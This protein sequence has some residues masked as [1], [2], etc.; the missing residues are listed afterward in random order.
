MFITINCRFVMFRVSGYLK[1]NSLPIIGAVTFVSYL[2][3]HAIKWLIRKCNPIQKIDFTA[4]NCLNQPKPGFFSSLF[5]K[6]V[7]N[8]PQISSDKIT[9]GQGEYIIFHKNPDGTKTPVS[10]EIYTKAYEVLQRY[11]AVALAKDGSETAINECANRDVLIKE[12]LKE[13][14]PTLEAI[15]IPRTLYEL[16]FIRKCINEDKKNGRICHRSDTNYHDQTS[17]SF[18]DQSSYEAYVAKDTKDLK[19]RKCWHLGYFIDEGNN[20]NDK[21]KNV[22]YRLNKTIFKKLNPDSTGLTFQ[23]ILTHAQNEI[24]Y[25][26]KYHENKE[27]QNNEIC[28]VSTLGIS[29]NF[30][31]ETYTPLWYPMG[32]RHD[33]DAQIIKNA[34]ALE[35][36][37]MARHA[38]FLYRGAIFKIDSVLN[39]KNKSGAYSLSYGTS[40]FAGNVYDGGGTAFPYMRNDVLD[41]YAIPVPFNKLK[42]SLFFV[43]SDNT[44]SQLYGGGESFHARTKVWKGF[45][46]LGGINFGVNHDKIDHLKSDLNKD[47]VLSQFNDF[48][49]S[50]FLLKAYQRA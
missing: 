35:C 9:V 18:S 8:L 50:A 32:I 39:R 11:S 43:S 5:G 40:L 27:Q 41:A 48:K 2:G 16:V 6:K 22:A 49:N 15:F 36:S 33:D 23:E 45:T 24:D 28:N 44:V 26:K 3:Y 46:S 34:L 25:L 19:E 1:G 37:T 42:N 14:D 13:I 21:V 4:N 47:E 10:E 20:N 7:C 29:K 38:L 12:K 30:Y 31:Y 17:K